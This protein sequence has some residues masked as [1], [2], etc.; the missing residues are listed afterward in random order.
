M[1]PPWRTRE[2]MP[3]MTASL[4]GGRPA[5]REYSQHSGRLCTSYQCH[6]VVF[7]GRP[8]L[9]LGDKI[10]MPQAAFREVGISTTHKE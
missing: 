1:A 7:L 5:G 2:T 3:T 8:G 9:E 10:I 4:R 6:S